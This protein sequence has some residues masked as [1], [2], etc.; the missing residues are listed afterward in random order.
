MNS[1]DRYA[2]PR[3]DVADIGAPDTLLSSRPRSVAWACVLLLA[4]MAVGLASLLPGIDPPIPGEP[5]AMTAMIWGITLAL[6]A[7]ELWILHC[8][9]QRRG[10]A[11]WTMV[12]LTAFGIAVGI[13][14]IEEDW[15]RAPIVAWLGIASGALSTVAAALLLARPAANWF[16]GVAAGR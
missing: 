7:V 10:W 8:V 16:K 6:L 9:W 5:A 4:S 12:A 1:S 13:P 14:V 3:T 2:P 15:T 11:R